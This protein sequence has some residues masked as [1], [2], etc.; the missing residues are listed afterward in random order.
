MSLP[1]HEGADSFGTLCLDCRKHNS[2]K[3]IIYENISLRWVLQALCAACNLWKTNYRFNHE[4]VYH[5]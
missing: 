4:N 1:I 2:E 5:P 3:A